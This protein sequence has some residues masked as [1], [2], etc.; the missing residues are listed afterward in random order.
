MKKDVND[1]RNLTNENVGAWN[2]NSARKEGVT[3]GAITAAVIGLLVLVTFGII[4]FS[5]YKGSQ[6]TDQPDA[7]PGA[8]IHITAHHA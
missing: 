4:A 5:L 8:G 7:K 1:P 2:E 6:Q 3:K